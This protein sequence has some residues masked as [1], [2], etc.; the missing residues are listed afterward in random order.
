MS[1]RLSLIETQKKPIVSG[2]RVL[3]YRIY[4]GAHL[5]SNTPMIRIQVD[6][7]VLEE[8]PT[9]RLP[10]FPAALI[11]KLPG[12]AQHGCSSGEAGG[13]VLRLNEGTWLGHVI[14]HVALELQSMVGMSVTRGKTRSV[15][16]KSGHYNIMYAYVSENVGLCAGRIAMEL[17]ASLLKPPLNKFSGLNKIYDL[18]I[19]GA[20]DLS[21][22]IAELERLA[23]EEKFGPT[24]K[25]LVDE[26][27]K[28]NIPWHRVD[29]QS[30]VQLGT[31]RY[32]K[33]IR[34]SITSNTS[35]IAVE[36][37]SDKSLTKKLLINLGIPAPVGDVVRTQEGAVEVAHEIGF[38]VT[39]K[40]MD[41]NHG[42]GV[43]TN[44]LSDEEVMQAFTRA[45]KHSKYIIVEQFYAGRD[46]RVLVVNGEV[47]AVAERIP[48]H[49]TGNGV[50]TIAKLIESIN[51][52]PHRGDG[53]EESMTRIKSDET[54]LAWL[55]RT[56]MTLESV[57]AKQQRVVLSPGANISTG[58]TA[59]DRT[60]EIHEDNAEI[61]R[62]AALTIGLDIAGIDMVIPDI[63]Q[64]WRE[65]GGGIVEVNAA[66]GFRMHLFPEEGK[67]QN[68]AK[69][70][71]SYLFPENQ[72]ARVPVI[73]VTGTNGKSS[74]VRM[75]VH[76]LRHSGLRVGFTSTSG[77]FVD[78]ACIWKGDA[79]GP[80]SAR[81]LLNNPTI[82]I[83]VLETARGGII[84]EGL[85]V[86]ECD[87]GAVLNVTA[88]H[89]GIS[90]IESLDDLADV[91][92]VVTE[93][94]QRDGVSVLNAD[95]PRTLKMA[96]YAGGSI[97]YFS[98]APTS[99]LILKEHIE[100]NGCAVTHE[101]IGGYM[102]V[103]LHKNGIRTPIINVNDIP[104]TIHGKAAFNVENALA[105]TAI[106]NALNIE[107]QMIKLALSSFYSSYDQN[108]GRFNIYDG[109]GF[110][111]IMDY[112]HNPAALKAL[113][114]FTEEMRD[115]YLRVIGHISVPGDRRDEDIEEIARI[116]ASSLDL[117]VFREDDDKR[118][119]APGEIMKLL[120][121]SA[122]SSGCP[123]NNIICIET[124]EGATDFCLQ[125]AHPGDLVIL[126]PSGVESCWKQ[127]LNFQPTYLWDG[128]ESPSE[129]WEVY[130]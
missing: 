88:D 1:N 3:E 20:F 129:G 2:L 39:V 64:S 124:E 49:V 89:L 57:P 127:M 128:R 51:S 62:R 81:L 80:K 28:R 85:A 123:E 75:L 40:P 55:K 5:Y 87:V 72:R 110:R 98:M 70:V 90:G 33:F 11:E 59:V 68:V 112:A 44:L 19:P 23:K 47:A 27:E 12:L 67:A 58:G 30:L 106:A 82:D 73:A 119:R 114:S 84:R 121:E 118:G 31:G 15:K 45:T 102:H 24:T 130:A 43:S 56:N 13:F 18:S 91:K 100:E 34:A 74:T 36:T 26:A 101:L 76:I 41:G 48:A 10:G 60:D 46:Y 117:V 16:D 107:P 111:V 14:E 52:N 8:W 63:R 4:R 6:L 50:D 108:P 126:T 66:P 54:L 78:Y 113:F 115:H 105:A 94:V 25:S 79:S 17:V 93:A 7:G 37:A 22:A 69:S 42:R 71:I 125:Q 86:S 97:C 77:I 35:N 122:L 96:K 32:H 116:A 92:S 120:K 21:K 104:A 95:D 83:A 53:H 9:D 61:A 38:P 109:H 103:V 29:D 65:T 99:N